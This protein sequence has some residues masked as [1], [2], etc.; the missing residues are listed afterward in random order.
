[1]KLKHYT[2]VSFI[3]NRL[4]KDILKALLRLQR[5]HRPL[6]K[7]VF[8]ILP[9]A[10]RIIDISVEDVILRIDL[11]QELDFQY[12][13]GQYD[14]KELEFLINSY[15]PG[16]HFIDAGANIGF[17]SLFFSRRIPDSIVL[18]FEPDPYNLK[19]FNENIALNDFHNINVAPYA[20]SD[21]D[22]PKDLIINCPRNRG[23]SSFLLPESEVLNEGFNKI[24]V[25]CKT[26]LAG[27]EENNVTSI[28]ALKMDIEGYEYP[29]LS[30][31]FKQAPAS[32]YPSSLV[33][34]SFDT[35]ISKVG[36]NPI[37]LLLDNG[38]KL[39]GQSNFNYFLKLSK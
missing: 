14:K 35:T 2:G 17:Y 27:L 39:V 38:Y 33:V 26:L 32:L 3:S 1:M 4:Y 9:N 15:E 16:S 19:R 25:E 13:M 23:G 18:A 12:L 5:G 30:K 28:S 22:N 36:G 11:S 24:S 7:Y 20:L 31:F 37:E 34:E 29:V 10:L 21:S 8:P 6:R